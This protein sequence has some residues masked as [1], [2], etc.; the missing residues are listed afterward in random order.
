MQSNE[1]IAILQGTKSLSLTYRGDCELKLVS[2]TNSDWGGDKETRRSTSGY[3]FTLAG[4]PVSWSSRRPSTV[5]LSATKAEYIAAAKATKEA[6]WIARFLEELKVS[7]DVYL[8]SNS[9]VTTKE[10][11]A[12]QKTLRTT[13]V[14]NI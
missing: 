7:C 13:G 9:T 2:Y 8:R 6:I 12:S 11:L 10:L 5:A 4:A 14:P 3:V 1:Y